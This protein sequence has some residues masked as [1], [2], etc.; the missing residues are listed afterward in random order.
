[1]IYRNFEPNKGKRSSA[2]QI[3]LVCRD[4][5]TLVFVE[6]KTRNTEDYGRPAEAVHPDQQRRISRGALTWLR[7]LDNPEVP[8]RFDVVEVLL[9]P[10]EKPKLELVQDAFSLAKPYRW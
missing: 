1:M 7:M 5:E 6:V 3:D 9:L 4:R 8:Y 10:N 2:G